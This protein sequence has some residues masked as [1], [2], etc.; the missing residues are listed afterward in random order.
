MSFALD[1]EVLRSTAVVLTLDVSWTAAQS[2]QVTKEMIIM[3]LG[4]A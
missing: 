1:I 3:S 4:K 2:V